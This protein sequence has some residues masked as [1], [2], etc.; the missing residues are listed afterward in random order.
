MVMGTDWLS[1][2]LLDKLEP[3]VAKAMKASAKRMSEAAAKSFESV[4]K[5]TKKFKIF[6]PKFAKKMKAAAPYASIVLDMVGIFLQ[7]LDALG[8]LEPIMTLFNGVLQLIGGTVMQTLAPAMQHLAEVLFSDDMMDLW[9]LLGWLIGTVL[10]VALGTFATILKALAPI[11]KPLILL[12][13]MNMVIAIILITKAIG[14]L[15]IS[16]LLPLMLAIYVFGLGI[17]AI[18][19]I[20]FGAKGAM[21]DWSNLMLPIIGGMAAGIAQIIMLQHGG[22]VTR[23]TLALIGEKGPEAVL[24]LNNEGQIAGMGNSNTE[25][26]WATEDNGEKLDVLINVMRGR[27]RLI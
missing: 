6:G 2:D 8:V 21:G 27:G 10:S 4:G 18:A 24:P 1:Q 26:L 19:E 17:A 11:L 25:L 14:I 5:D 9:K 13:G 3:A 22:V 16:A 20:I 23:P 12:F 7:I 15:I